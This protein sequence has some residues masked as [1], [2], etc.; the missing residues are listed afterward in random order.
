MNNTTNTLNGSREMTQSCHINR[1][2]YKKVTQ[3]ILQKTAKKEVQLIAEKL[4][5]VS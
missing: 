1:K 3:T 5:V 4:L 2:G